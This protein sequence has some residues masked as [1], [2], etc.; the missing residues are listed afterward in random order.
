MSNDEKNDQLV[1]STRLR[2]LIYTGHQHIWRL[3]L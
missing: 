2:L 3:M 1:Y